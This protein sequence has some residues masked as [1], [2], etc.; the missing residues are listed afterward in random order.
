MEA[1]SRRVMEDAQRHGD[2]VAHMHACTI[3]GAAAT[4]RGR[5]EE[6]FTADRRNRDFDLV[7]DRKIMAN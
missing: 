3:T 2:R 6:P 7:A 1:E 5:F 4:F